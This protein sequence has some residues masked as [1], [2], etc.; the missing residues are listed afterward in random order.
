MPTNRA[1]PESWDADI[2]RSVAFYNDWFLSFAPDAYRTERVAA[3]ASVQGML[4][5]TNYLL[6]ITPKQLRERPEILAALR[7]STAPPIARDRLIGLA[8]VSKSLVE[9]MEKRSRLPPR[10]P[11]AA[12]DADLAKIAKLI[13]RLTDVDIFPWIEE[14]R[15]PHCDEANRAS[16]IVADR[17]CDA[18]ADQIIRNAQETSTD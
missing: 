6:E 8:G 1:K 15:I 14:N 9:S 7:M 5:E 13:G 3:A 18:R 12:L 2:K 10:M 17:V 4:A 16:M 11:K